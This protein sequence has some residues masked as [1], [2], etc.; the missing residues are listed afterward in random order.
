MYL[1]ND[2]EIEDREL[3]QKVSNGDSKRSQCKKF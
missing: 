3:D 2:M 1:P